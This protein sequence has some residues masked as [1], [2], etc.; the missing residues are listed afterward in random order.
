MYGKIV[1]GN[2]LSAPNPMVIGNYKVYNPRAEQYISEGYLE[3]IET[4]YPENPDGKYYVKE[5]VERDG[6]IYGEWVEGTAPE[7]PPAI[8]SLEERTTA[9][10]EEVNVLGEAFNMILEG[11]TE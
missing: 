8:P 1:E 10:E 4:D 6:A 11:V 3:I 9:L 7:I 5:Y 2:I